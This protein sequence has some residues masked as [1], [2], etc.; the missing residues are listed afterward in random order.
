LPTSF[1]Y[2]DAATLTSISPELIVA[3]SMDDPIFKV[4]PI[5][6]RNTGKLR[7][8]IKDSYR[9]LMALRGLGGEPTRV[10]KVGQ[11]LFE[12]LPG[13]YGEFETVDEVEMTNRASGFPA[14][15]DVPVDVSD[16]V[17]ESQEQL[18]VR[19]VNRM[20]QIAWL[21]AVQSTFAV[22]L[23]GG[24]IGHT[25][26]YVGQTVIV[27]PLWSDT[28]NALPLKNLRDLQSNFGRGTSNNFGGTAEAW[29]NSRTANFLLANYNPQDLGRERT[30][31]GATVNDL[32]GISRILV[33]QNAPQ[34]MV[35]DDGYLD[36]TGVFNLYLPD[37]KVMVVGKRPNGETPGEFQMTRNANNPNFEAKPYAFVDDR[38]QGAMKTVPP[39]IDVH[40]GFNGGPV[41]ERA[42]QIVVLAVA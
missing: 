25:E 23:P 6:E 10:N 17:A 38:T 13:A 11:R 30:I 24:G 37:G 8:T 40:Q 33:S 2:Q 3:A 35:W 29:M 26:S 27:A 31:A 20:K 28:Q 36:D 9:G 32:P 22:P 12:A 34:I 4:F 14:N 19:Q 42:S 21:L 16:L 18:T 5:R 15:M 7:W 41:M 39:R 1:T